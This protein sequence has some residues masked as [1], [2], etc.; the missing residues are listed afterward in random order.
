MLLTVFYPMENDSSV[1]S[2]PTT[3]E[4]NARL[5][6]LG[7]LAAF[8]V[9][10]VV[11]SSLYVYTRPASDALARG[12]AR[13]IPYP[14]AIVGTDVILV[15][16]FLFEYD[17][18]KTYFATQSEMEPLP[19]KETKKN[20]M[21]TLINRV[22]IERFA[23]N[24]KIALDPAKE[25]ELMQ[26]LLVSGNITEEQLEAQVHETFGWEVEEFKKR[27]VRPVVL[28]TQLSEAIAQD[29]ETQKDKR[30]QID[31]AYAR[32]KNNE[33]FSLVASETNEDATAKMGGDIGFVNLMTVPES[34]R[35][36]VTAM[37]EGTYADVLETNEAYYILRLNDKKE[38]EESVEYSLS[39]I[40][41]Y[42]HTLEDLLQDRLEHTRVWRF[43]GRE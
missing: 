19:E 22:M 11:G 17:G 31:A 29:T 7:L 43:L 38:G 42:K 18:L 41:V 6:V 34:W 36:T 21:D 2:S 33:D 10:F 32:L 15:R 1:V 14:A 20:L 26:N 4:K 9:L 12:L 35:P 28:S 16:D 5:F 30:A 13:V 40:S 3:R 8:M 25:A 24:Y 39:V 27:I 23:K 37:A